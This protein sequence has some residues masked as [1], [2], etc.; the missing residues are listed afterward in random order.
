MDRRGHTPLQRTKPELQ[1]YA[2]SRCRST[3]VTSVMD[4]T[5]RAVDYRNEQEFLEGQTQFLLGNMQMCCIHQL[6][7]I[8]DR[9]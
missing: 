9:G 8:L 3:C 2:Y 4:G 1:T 5:P 7:A 6:V